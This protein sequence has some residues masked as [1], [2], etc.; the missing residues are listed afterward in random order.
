[1]VKDSRRQEMFGLIIT[2]IIAKKS[3]QKEERDYGYTS[4]DI[5]IADQPRLE[6]Y[7]KVN[8]NRLGSFFGNL[9]GSTVLD[10]SEVDEV[11]PLTDKVIDTPAKQMSLKPKI[12]TTKSFAEIQ[13]KLSGNVAKQHKKG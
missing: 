4:R 9:D 1:V 12:S 6:R 8:R 2:K 7:L 5:A 3:K 10:D 13:I 11:A